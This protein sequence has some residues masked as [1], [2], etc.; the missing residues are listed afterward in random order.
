MSK[1]RAEV[2]RRMEQQ[3]TK[4]KIAGMS[5]ARRAEFDRDLATK[6]LTIGAIADKYG[7]SKTTVVKHRDEH[8]RPS[9]ALAAHNDKLDTGRNALGAMWEL[10][11]EAKSVIRDLRNDPD[12]DAR[13][14]GNVEQLLGRAHDI[15]RSVGEMTGEIRTKGA[16][17]DAPTNQTVIQV[18]SI[19]KIPGTPTHE[20]DSGEMA[21]DYGSM[22]L[23]DITA[24]PS[25]HEAA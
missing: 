5:P 21:P 12:A 7:M 22:K 9:M 14:L 16:P 19:P 24:E 2:L 20:S 3:P 15:V 18:I 17:A 1:T 11:D 4:G 8:V 10:A 23:L 25:D 13:K 6:R